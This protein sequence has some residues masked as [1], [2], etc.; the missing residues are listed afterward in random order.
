MLEP[1]RASRELKAGVPANGLGTPVFYLP[2]R[3]IDAKIAG[4]KTARL[5]T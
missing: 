4:A 5:L 3:L 1:G 2:K